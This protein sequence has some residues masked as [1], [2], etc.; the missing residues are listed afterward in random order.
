MIFKTTFKRNKT[1]GIS[2]H[3]DGMTQGKAI[4]LCNALSQ[5][6][7][8]SPVGQDVLTSLHNAIQRETSVE[9][10]EDNQELFVVSQ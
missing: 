5:H 10:K 8:T 4:A 3:F 6:C 1:G 2:I 9:Y 7:K